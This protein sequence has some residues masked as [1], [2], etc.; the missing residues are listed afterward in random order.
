MEEESFTDTTR[1]E[2]E[3]PFMLMDVGKEKDKRLFIYLHG[4]RQNMNIFRSYMEPLLDLEGYHLFIQGPYPIYD[5]D[6]NKRIEEWGRA[7]YLYDGNQDSFHKSLEHTS[8]F[9]DQLI[10]KRIAN[11]SKFSSMTIIGYSMGGYLAGYYTL[12]RAPRVDNLVVIGSRIKTEYFKDKQH[13]YTELEVLAIHG[14]DDRSVE[15]AP[16]KRSCNQLA[17]WGANVTYKELNGGH[18]LQEKY[19]NEIRKWLLSQ[20]N[21]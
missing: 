14:K 8:A 18:K 6:R 11:E 17:K 5:R 12:S 20:K 3:V 10:D 16:Q 7:W 2:I 15:G 4:F 21:K 13:N 19:L 1:F 9:L